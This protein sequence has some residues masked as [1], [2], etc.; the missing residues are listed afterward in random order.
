V[1]DHQQTALARHCR[2]AFE[3]AQPRLCRL[4]LCGRA[5]VVLSVNSGYE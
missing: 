5:S 2:F 4:V 1:N 3:T